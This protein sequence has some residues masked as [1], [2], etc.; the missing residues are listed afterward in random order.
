MTT[1]TDL[2]KKQLA[3]ILSALDDAP[4]SPANKGEALRAI[5]RSAQR[6]GLTTDDVLAAAPGLLDHR[7]SPADF[8]VELHD[9]GGAPVPAT[10]APQD[11]AQAQEGDAAGQEPQAPTEPAHAAV[12]PAAGKRNAKA[13][14]KAAKVAKPNKPAKVAPSEKPTPRTGTKQA[15]MIELL[16]RPEGATV[17]QIAAATGWQHHTVRGAIAGAQ[18]EAGAHHRG[19]P[20]PRGRS[21]QGGCQGQRHRLSHHRLRAPAMTVERPRRRG[22]TSSTRPTV[23]RPRPC[24]QSGASPAPTWTMRS[25]SWRAP[26]ASPSGASSASTTTASSAA[27]RR[28]GVPT[29]PVPVPSPSSRCCGS[30]SWSCSIVCPRAARRSSARRHAAGLTG[31]TPRPYAAA[32]ARPAAAVSFRPD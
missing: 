1:T 2:S 27:G 21:Q 17:E 25:P 6:S 23:P 15:Q 29:Y 24:S 14:A 18:E 8:R 5:G 7:M 3:T 10:E 9:Q 20:H 31:P 26:R 12:T 19:H 32:A 4:R 16:K 11:A 28:T 30:R 22:A 13:K